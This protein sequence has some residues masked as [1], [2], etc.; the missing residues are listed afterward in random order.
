MTPKSLS[1]QSQVSLLQW[2]LFY[3]KACIE[4][5]SSFE[6][7]QFKCDMLSKKKLTENQLNALIFGLFS[8]EL[9]FNLNL[10]KQINI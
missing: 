1:K 6:R 3:A 8:F 9:F 5:R 10:R 2:F 4:N 7:R